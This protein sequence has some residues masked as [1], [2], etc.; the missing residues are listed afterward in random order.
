MLMIISSLHQWRS[1]DFPKESMI[2]NFEKSVRLK[3]PLKMNANSNLAQKS[4]KNKRDF[5]TT[6]LFN[7]SIFCPA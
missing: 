2:P 5:D 6:L 1:R 7:D 3:L 4:A